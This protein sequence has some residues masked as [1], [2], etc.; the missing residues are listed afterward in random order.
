[1]VLKIDYWKMHRRIW[2][3][4]DKI[5]VFSKCDLNFPSSMSIKWKSDMD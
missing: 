4:D 2:L 3:L 1:M 5:L